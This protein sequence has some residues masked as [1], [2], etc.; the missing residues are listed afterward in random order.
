MD[1]C[2]LLVRNGKVFEIA[3][4]HDEKSDVLDRTVGLVKAASGQ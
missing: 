4:G 3:A 1:M 2:N